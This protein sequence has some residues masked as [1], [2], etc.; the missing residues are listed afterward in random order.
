LLR[1]PHRFPCRVRPPRSLRPSTAIALGL[2]AT[3]FF[4]IFNHDG[5]H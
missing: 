2:A 4:I 5:F 1:R 3:V